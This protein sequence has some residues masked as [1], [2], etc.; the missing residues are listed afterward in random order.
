MPFI[1]FVAFIESPLLLQG[2]FR[3]IVLPQEF[4]VDFILSDRPDELCKFDVGHITETVAHNIV[5]LF[6]APVEQKRIQQHWVFDSDIVDIYPIQH[7]S[8]EIGSPLLIG[9]PD[10]THPQEVYFL[11]SHPLVSDVLPWRQNFIVET[12]DQQS[13]GVGPEERDNGHF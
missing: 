2:L 1:A 3:V 7:E 10:G 4:K 9:Q 11:H 13:F 12:F 8:V 5:I 6:P